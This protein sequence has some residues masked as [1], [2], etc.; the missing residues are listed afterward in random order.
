[1]YL[2][3]LALELIGETEGKGYIFP[4]PHKDKVK[5]INRHA[6]S[7]AIANNCPSGCKNDCST[8]ENSDCKSDDQIHEE[9]NRIGIGHFT[10]HDL[11]RTAATF[12]AQAGEMDEVIDTILNHA[13]Q[14]VIKVYN[15]YRYDKEKQAALETWEIN[16]KS[17]V[18]GKEEV[19]IHTIT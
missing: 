5:A 1:M 3:D 13:K 7:R 2:T 12:M 18:F 6:L 4:C 17:I 16:L 15:Q 11:R 10:P 14:R 8:C 9:K 19:L